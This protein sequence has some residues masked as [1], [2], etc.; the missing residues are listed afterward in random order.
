LHNLPNTADSAEAAA[1]E[2]I[3]VLNDPLPTL[4]VPAEERLATTQRPLSRNI[5]D[6]E[7]DVGIQP[8]T[9]NARADF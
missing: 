6:L 3:W 1:H 9:R 8:L 5:R 2:A 7:E 4:T